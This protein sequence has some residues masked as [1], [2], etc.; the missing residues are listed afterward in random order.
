[1]LLGIFLRQ[2]IVMKLFLVKALISLEILRV[3]HNFNLVKV[4]NLSTFNIG[5]WFKIKD[6]IRRNF[7]NRICSK[8]ALNH[9]FSWGSDPKDIKGHF[10]NSINYMLRY[11]R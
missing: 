2:G 11:I 10:R 3:F 8:I 7:K 4:P 6:I 5:H 1:M 9:I